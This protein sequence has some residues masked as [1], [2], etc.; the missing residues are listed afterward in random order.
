MQVQE[1]SPYKVTVGLNAYDCALL[2]EVCDEWGEI[3]QERESDIRHVETLGA[4]L[5]ALGK[6]AIALWTMPVCGEAE[7]TVA[8]KEVG[9]T[10]QA[11]T[12]NA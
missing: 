2:A 1:I 11:E 9:F 10:E 8:L 5:H 3:S 7:Y 6:A 12:Q 4:A